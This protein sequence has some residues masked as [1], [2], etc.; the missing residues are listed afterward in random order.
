MS[1]C[2]VG[3]C[4]P[5]DAPAGDCWFTLVT[6]SLKGYLI[7]RVDECVD[8]LF[9]ITILI[10]VE[11]R[12]NG[13]SDRGIAGSHVA[14]GSAFFPCLLPSRK[15]DYLLLTLENVNFSI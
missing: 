2:I 8:C 7:D 1:A 11:T 14:P 12:L 10:H 6:V 5:G 3:D 4:F 13:F 9:L 15:G